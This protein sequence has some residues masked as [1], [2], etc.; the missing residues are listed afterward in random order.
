MKKYRMIF[1]IEEDAHIEDHVTK[2]VAKM[3]D[4]INNLAIGKQN[5]YKD[6]RHSVQD[7]ME[8][9]EDCKASDPTDDFDHLHI[10]YR[11]VREI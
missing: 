9:F 6:E 7:L 4:R 5:C 2:G 8:Y 3:R 1:I 10:V 11:S